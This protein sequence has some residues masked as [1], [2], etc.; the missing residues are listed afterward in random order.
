MPNH[1]GEAVLPH[2]RPDTRTEQSP[3][4]GGPASPSPV[5][6]SS[7]ELATRFRV[8]ATRLVRRL[9]SEAGIGL[10]PTLLSALMVIGARGP[11]T[12]GRL[13]ELEGLAPPSITKIVKN[14][15]ARDLVVR[16]ADPEDRRVRRVEVTS[17]GEALLDEYR[18]RR[19]G[20]L[21]SR[22]ADLTEHELD[23]VGI[24]CDLLDRVLK[25]PTDD[26]RT[27]A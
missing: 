8:R 1:Q 16:V 11:V 5:R 10:S 25:E 20:W 26:D 23:A 22:F 6:E 15:E 17:A 7:E 9:R 2:D 3:G 24:V 18:S 27:P 19:T 14:L 12:L 13:A 21:S 4:A